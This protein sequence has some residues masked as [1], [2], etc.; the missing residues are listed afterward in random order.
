[1]KLFYHRLTVFCN[2]TPQQATAKRRKR[3]FLPSDAPYGFAQFDIAPPHNELIQ[4]LP[5][6][7]KTPEPPPL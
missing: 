6:R 1:M 7:C 5:R 4:S 2:W 3:M